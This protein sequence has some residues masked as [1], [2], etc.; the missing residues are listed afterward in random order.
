[1]GSWRVGRVVMAL[2]LKTSE[3]KLSQVRILYPPPC[4]AKATWQAGIRILTH[5]STRARWLEY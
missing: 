1:M 4:K 3:R 2:V 5:G